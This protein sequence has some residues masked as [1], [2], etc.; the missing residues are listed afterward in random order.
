M[1]VVTSGL[2]SVSEQPFAGKDGIELLHD[3][4]SC[5]DL[6]EVA[7]ERKGE[8]ERLVREQAIGRVNRQAQDL[9]RRGGG[10][11]FDVDATGGAD[12]EDRPLRL[13]IHD[14][15]DVALGYDVGGRYDEDLMDLESLDPHPQDLGSVIECL[16]RVSRQLDTA[17]LAPSSGMH[18]RLD[19]D[20]AAQTP[21][22][23]FSLGRRG[24]NITVGDRDAGGLEQC[25]SLILVQVHDGP[26]D[27][28]SG[29]FPERRWSSLQPRNNSP[30]PTAFHETSSGFDLGPHP[31]GVERASS[32]HP[33]RLLHRHSPDRPSRP[34]CPTLR[35]PHPHW[36][37]SSAPR[38]EL[39]S[40]DGG[41]AVLVHHRIDPF[42]AENRVL[43]HRCAATAGSNYDRAL[44]PA[45]V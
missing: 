33:F 27:G 45:G 19:H 43:I 29:F 41:H 11:L 10:N 25:A 9:F 40:Q 31:T 12:H 23:R 37:G 32:D 22:D 21:R 39:R 26:H 3:P 6:V 2:I 16:T 38:L 13:P 30:H 34:G 42:Q 5:L 18:L 15:A 35:R 17:G 44:A 24:G 7:I 20:G 36:S 1:G 28:C 14:E 4:R 8:R